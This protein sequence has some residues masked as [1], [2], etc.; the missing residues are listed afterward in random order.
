MINYYI[1]KIKSG[2]HDFGWTSLVSYSKKPDPLNPLS[3]TLLYIVEVAV[4]LSAESARNITNVQQ[5][6]PPQQGESGVVE[7]VPFTFEC[8]KAV[9]TIRLKLPENMKTLEAKKCV[10]RSIQVWDFAF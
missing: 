7:V 8:I 1:F 4:I 5:L 10:L 3:G 2:L 6:Q 9:S